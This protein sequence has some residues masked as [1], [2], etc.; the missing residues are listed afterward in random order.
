MS[1]MRRIYMATHTRKQAASPAVGPVA[2]AAAGSCGDG[3]RG[4]TPI[5]RL[6]VRVGFPSRSEKKP[7][8]ILGISWWMVITKE[9][10]VG[11][12]EPQEET[13]GVRGWIVTGAGYW[14]AASHLSGACGCWRKRCYG[15]KETGVGRKPP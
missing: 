13:K 4:F 9:D 15:E 2:V 1:E 12:T 3:D 10:R 5:V 11:R 6:Q 14:M 7:Q 8:E